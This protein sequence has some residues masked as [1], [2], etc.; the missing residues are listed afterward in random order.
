MTTPALQPI[1]QQQHYKNLLASVEDTDCKRFEYSL[2]NILPKKAPEAAAIFAYHS[3]THV[4]KIVARYPHEDYH[5]AVEAFISES[6]FSRAL[7]V[8]HTSNSTYCTLSVLYELYTKVETPETI[9]LSNLMFERLARRFSYEDLFSVALRHKNPYG[10]KLAIDK[11]SSPPSWTHIDQIVH[12]GDISLIRYMCQK[13]EGPKFNLTAIECICG[14]DGIGMF[15]ILQELVA[16]LP[17]EPKAKTLN[18]L[19][20]SLRTSVE[21][22][23]IDRVQLFLPYYNPR[24][25]QGEIL[26]LASQV[27]NQEIFDLIVQNTPQPKKILDDMQQHYDASDIQLLQEYVERTLLK[28]KLVK[29]VA[30]RGSEKLSSVRKM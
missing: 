19:N 26:K 22:E 6:H 3:G 24:F 1:K 10:M 30:K 5:K 27:Q 16:K 15:D 18:I 4:E 25:E 2:D 28:K 29:A 9:E 23:F 8:L 21:F 13:F 14:N 11:R 7:S 17:L 12:T 20:D